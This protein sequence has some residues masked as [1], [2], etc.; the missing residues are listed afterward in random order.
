MKLIVGLGNPGIRYEQTKHNVG[1]RVIDALYEECNRSYIRI[2][3]FSSSA[4]YINLQITRYADDMARP[5]DYPREADDLHEQQW[6]CCRRTHQDSL[7][8]HPRNC[9]SST[10]TFT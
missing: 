8:F 2:Q 4:S 6:H 10:M 7:R 1:F 9:A 5:T 3:R